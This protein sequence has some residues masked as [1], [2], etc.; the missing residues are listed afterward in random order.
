MDS[1]TDA[2]CDLRTVNSDAV[3]MGAADSDTVDSDAVDSGKIDLDCCTLLIGVTVV[4]FSTDLSLSVDTWTSAS[5]VI[6]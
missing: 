5:S 6:L 4:S 1:I 2:C 3:D